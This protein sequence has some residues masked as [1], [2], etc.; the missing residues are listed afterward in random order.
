MAT[1]L[2]IN[3]E[4]LDSTSAEDRAKVIETLSNLNVIPKDTIFEPADDEPMPNTTSAAG[5]PGNIIDGA[6]DVIGGVGKALGVQDTLCD[7]AY[8]TA[9]AACK[10][11]TAEVGYVLC[12]AAAEKARQK[13]KE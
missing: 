13:C 4:L 2:R 10:A 7:G 9:L 11:Y 12:V 3:R 5:F 8:V 6:G 1:N